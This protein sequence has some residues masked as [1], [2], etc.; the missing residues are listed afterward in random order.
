MIRLVGHSTYISREVVMSSV[1]WAAH[2]GKANLHATTAGAAF[3]T[4]L[5]FCVLWFAPALFRVTAE[6]ADQKESGN[7]YDFGRSFLRWTSTRNNHTPRMQVDAACT[8]TRNG[9]SREYFL[10]A[11]CTGEKMYADKDLIH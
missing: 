6:E 8:L 11:L 4:V 3:L 5:V 2:G 10:S 9:R 7:T 1:R